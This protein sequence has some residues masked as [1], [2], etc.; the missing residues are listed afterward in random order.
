MGGMLC[1]SCWAPIF[2]STFS[3]Q[4]PRN[5]R[6]KTQTRGH[7]QNFRNYS[8]NFP[9]ATYREK[10]KENVSKHE[11]LLP[12]WLHHPSSLFAH[13]CG[14]YYYQVDALSL[15]GHLPWPAAW[16]WCS[17]SGPQKSIT[18]LPRSAWGLALLE[19][20][21]SLAPHPGG[22]LQTRHDLFV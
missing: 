18:G 20:S 5:N 4:R 8:K 22:V 15:T 21:T 1:S 6:N 9:H 10:N 16:G 13:L 7:L 11:F 2:N 17:P 14:L 12:R 3:Y 19:N